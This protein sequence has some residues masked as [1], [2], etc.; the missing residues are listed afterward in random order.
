MLAFRPTLGCTMPS[1]ARILLAIRDFRAAA[2]A[3]AVC[4]QLGFTPT[5]LAR[6]PDADDDLPPAAALIADDE[7]TDAV[8]RRLSALRRRAPSLPIVLFPPAHKG[9]LELVQNVEGVSGLKVVGC[10]GEADDA[11]RL[12]AGLDRLLASVPGAAVLGA[13]AELLPTG[14]PR[15]PLDIARAVLRLRVPG[16][17]P[18]VTAIAQVLGDAPRTLQRRWPSTLPTPKVF[19][20]LVTLVYAI[21]IHAWGGASW[22]RIARS[23]GMEPKT[24]SHLRKQWVPS[25]PGTDQLTTAL[26]VLAEHCRAPR[27]AVERALTILRRTGTDSGC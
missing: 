3:T 2:V 21:Y 9:I 6:L 19:D 26:L 15:P 8:L 25:A 7:P 17:H 22:E 18:S 12:R 11:E 13:L 5:P 23:L 14:G 1:P 4:M 10:W 16:K 24:L 20:D 27:A